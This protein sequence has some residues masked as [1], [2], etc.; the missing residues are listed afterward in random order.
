MVTLIRD[1]LKQDREPTIWITAT[2]PYCGQKYR[3]PKQSSYR[4]RTCIKYECIRKSLHSDTLF[5]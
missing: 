5:Y 3:Y 1:R 4:P 2:C